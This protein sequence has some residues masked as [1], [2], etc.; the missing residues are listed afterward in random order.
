MGL[1]AGAIVVAAALLL[2]NWPRIVHWVG[3]HVELQRE[4][5][6]MWEAQQ[7][8]RAVAEAM[9]APRSLPR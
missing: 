9:T 7:R 2:H 5:H 1:G 4:R 3:F 6:Q 8:R